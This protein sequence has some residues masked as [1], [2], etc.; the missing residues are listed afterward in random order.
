MV[1]HCKD[2][3]QTTDLPR[4][5]TIEPILFLSKMLNDAEQ[6][7]WLTELEVAGL[8]WTIRKIRHMI[9]ASEHPTIIY[10]DHAA[11]LGIVKQTSLNTVS[12]EKLNLR[13]VRASEYLQQFRLDVRYKPGRTHF[14]PD[15]LSCLASRETKRRSDEQQ[16]GILDTLHTAAKET[17]ALA[18]SIVEL[19]GDFKKRLIEGYE[20]DPRWKRILDVLRRNQTLK[21]ED[22]ATLP[23]ERNKEGLI[24]YRDPEYGPRLCVPD[25]DGLTKE[26]FQLTHD[27]MGHPGYHRT[28][29]RL[30]QGLYLHKLSSKLHDYIRHCPVCQL[31]QTPRHK[32]Y[33]NL[34]PIITPPVPFYMIT[35]DFILALPESKDGWNCVLSV[36]D[37]FSKRITFV[38]GK[39]T[40]KT[41]DWARSL[42]QQL[43]IAGWGVPKM[44]L[45][46]RDPKF[47]NSLW[48]EIF[49]ILNVQLLYST[50]YHPQTDGA[51]ERKNQTAEIAL[52]F[53][54]AGMTDN[55]SWPSI[56]SRLQ[57]ALNNSTSASTGKSPNEILYSF[58]L[59][60][61]LDLA[62]AS[63]Q[64]TLPMTY[65]LLTNIRNAARID[66]KDAIAFAAMA[67]KQLYDARHQQKSFKSGDM[68]NLRLH[69]GYILPAIKNKKL[70]QQFVGPVRVKRRVGRLAYE[71]D[72]PP[73]WKIHPVI[74]IAH[75]EPAST[76]VEDPYDRARP[77]H[78]GQ[79]YVEGDTETSKSY[80]IE[81]L[82]GKRSLKRY[83][84]TRIQ[85]LV[86][87]KGYGPE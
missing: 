36:T 4:K 19:S 55:R 11:T 37:K 23:F 86:R 70:Q 69:K 84:K 63:T 33:G 10:T 74:S 1:Y 14:A 17:W 47:L 48:K 40:W 24:H 82:L 3:G 6:R 34:Q 27:E 21:N 28:H 2:E 22:A 77:D 80:K 46:D 85:Y 57:A 49:E 87:W 31:N 43:D 12:V 32:P 51:S 65:E 25:Y 59:R 5:S 76:Q 18:T 50:T 15:A 56:L 8:V 9:E 53:Y 61:P 72:I 52:G 54:L 30:T 67:M 73:H 58:R 41:A 13:L 7:Y 35:I 83:G 66:A 75:L 42:L 44:I 62:V 78:P 68:V 38:P 60:E 45:S 16:E 39:N 20:T 29:E 81:A 79:V 71:L 64:A 26:V